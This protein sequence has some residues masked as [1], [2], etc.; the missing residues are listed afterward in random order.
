MFGTKKNKLLKEVIKNSNAK[1]SK[2]AAIELMNWKNEKEITCIKIN[3]SKDKIIP[4]TKKDDYIIEGGQH[5]MIIDKANEI[6]AILNRIVMMKKS[7]F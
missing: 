2:W 5:L 7:N 3:G 4:F 6:S 1:F